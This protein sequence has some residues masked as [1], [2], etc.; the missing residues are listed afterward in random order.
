MDADYDLFALAVEGGSLSA[1]ARAL[2]ISPAM[3]SKRLQRLE[4]RLGVRLLHRTTRRLVPTPAGERFHAD[5]VAIRAAVQEA[6]ARVTGARRE[7]AGR[8]RVSAPT[9]FGRL[10]VA[11]QLH[12]FLAAH[13][14][15]SLE[16]DLTDGFVDLVA[17]RVDVAVR[18][19]AA[20]PGGVAAHRLATSRRVLCA[21]PGYLATHGLPA[22]VR[23][24]KAHRLLA[25]EGQLPWHLVSGPR[26]ASVDGMS[27][28]RTNSSEIV[29][30]LAL[31]GVGIALRSLWDVG[32]ALASGALV[33]VL[34]EWEGSADVGI[35]AIHPHAALVPPAVTAFVAFL[36]ER[37]GGG[38]GGDQDQP[39]RSITPSPG[40]SA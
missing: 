4:A 19:A 32:D 12:H 36:A 35:Y 31:T 34:P 11:P 5:V 27:H 8:L 20:V 37:V 33:R 21:S 26:R 24:L 14:A 10:H 17:D 25:A 13:P 9:S 28:V 6:E 40:G 29:R 30:E 38:T 18:I 1:G 2:G 23:D 22:G 7:P 39:R 16:L 3:A 15:V